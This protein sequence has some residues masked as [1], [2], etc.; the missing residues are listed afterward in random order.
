MMTKFTPTRR[1]MKIQRKNKT[2]FLINLSHVT[3]IKQRNTERK[4][5]VGRRKEKPTQGHCDAS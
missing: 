2:N 4:S 3:N 1:K 5:K